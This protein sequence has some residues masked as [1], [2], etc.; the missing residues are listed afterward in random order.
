MLLG[1]IQQEQ[2]AN[3][4][5]KMKGLCVLAGGGSPIQQAK[6]Q[7]KLAAGVS[8]IVVRTLHQLIGLM[9]SVP[10]VIGTLITSQLDVPIGSI[11]QVSVQARVH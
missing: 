3:G 1:L 2:H 6:Q 7:R 10:C 4:M 11:T 9:I 8:G 5:N